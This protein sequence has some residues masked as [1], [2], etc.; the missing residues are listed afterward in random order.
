MDDHLHPAIE[1]SELA[2]HLGSPHWPVVVDVRRAA[3]FEASETVIA[4]AVRRDPDAVEAWSDGL[5]APDGTLVVVYCVH[6]HEV[7]RGV[8]ERLQ[9]HGVDARILA[10]GFEAWVAAGL[11]TRR[12]VA[13]GPSWVTRSRPK[14]DRIAC[15]WLVRRF[16]DPEATFLTVPDDRVLAVA[17]ET[18]ATPY[19]VPG[20]TFTHDGDRC[21]F[22][23]FLALYGLAEPGLERLAEIVRGA[24]T[25]RFDLAPQAAGLLAVS[26]GLSDLTPDDAV[27]LEKGM[28]LYDALYAWCRRLTGETH[29]W[30][31]AMVA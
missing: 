1:P 31:P 26:L 4:G 20:V 12:R 27:M 9:A 28:L 2:D 25:G 11:P 7:S 29:S 22:D 24:D 15:P 13:A 3:A 21:S 8:A 16:V 18:G 5:V 19:D 17:A 6:G 30:P 10:G 14:I 23:A